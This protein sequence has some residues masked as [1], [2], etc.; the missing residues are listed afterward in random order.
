MSHISN[1]VLCLPTL[2]VRVAKLVL[3][4]R[5]FWSKLT[6]KR[7]ATYTNLTVHLKLVPSDAR[8]PLDMRFRLGPE[9]CALPGSPVYDLQPDQSGYEFVLE[10]SDGTNVVAR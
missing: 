3:P 4:G 9:G 1:C 6:C 5:G 8:C 10:V 2:Q 7:N